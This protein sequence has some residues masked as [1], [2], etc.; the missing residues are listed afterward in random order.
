MMKIDEKI[1]RS[2]DLERGRRKESNESNWASIKIEFNEIFKEEHHDRKK[3][4]HGNIIE[5]KLK[6]I[7]LLL[8]I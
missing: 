4:T 1:K 2:K 7:L 8:L 5:H 3:V 6:V